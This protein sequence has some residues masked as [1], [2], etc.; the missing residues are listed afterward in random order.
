[1][2]CIALSV[3]PRVFA[4]L[5]VLVGTSATATVA[6]SAASPALADVLSAR[7]IVV[8]TTA[9]GTGDTMTLNVERNLKGAPGGALTITGV[10]TSLCGDA[11]V[12]RAGQ[13]VIFARH[14]RFADSVLDAFWLFDAAGT[15]EISTV[16]DGLRYGHA[17]LDDVVAEIKG[18]LPDTSTELERESGSPVWPFVIPAAAAAGAFMRRRAAIVGIRAKY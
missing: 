3:A 9:A 11:G 10:V 2:R 18:A 15:L 5:A 16:D 1:M 14:L 12:G 7:Y 4:L 6:C 13:T 8:A 17:T